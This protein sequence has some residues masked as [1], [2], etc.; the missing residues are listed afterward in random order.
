LPLAHLLGNTQP[1]DGFSWRQAL[2]RTEHPKGIHDLAALGRKLAARRVADG[3]MLAVPGVA[4]W[5]HFEAW[6]RIAVGMVGTGAMQQR[7]PPS[8][9]GDRSTIAFQQCY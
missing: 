2:P 9:L 4:R 1:L 8:K 7:A 6:A 3:N 5:L